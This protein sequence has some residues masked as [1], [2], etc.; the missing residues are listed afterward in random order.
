MNARC[1]RTTV[2]VVAAMML[3]FG[4]PL[5]AQ[6]ESVTISLPPTLTFMV[7]DVTVSTTAADGATRISFSNALLLPLKVLRI[8]VRADASDFS[9]PAGTNKISSNA[10]TWTTANAQNG[11]GMNGTLSASSNVTVFQSDL[12]ALS[13]GVDLNWSLGPPGAAVRA[14]VHSLVLRWKLE[15]VTP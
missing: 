12:G 15:S 7:S 5:M 13:G 14:G 11:V 6:L 2:P 3:L 4:A 10:V 1:L 9:P 8:S